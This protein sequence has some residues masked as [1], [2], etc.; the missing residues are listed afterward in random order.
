MTLN[1]SQIRDRFP[2]LNRPVIF[3]DNPGG[4]QICRQ[5][6][7]RINSYLVETN[8]N[9]GGRFAT[10]RAS[11]TLVEEARAALADFLNAARPEE[12]VFGPNMTTLTFAI[13]RALAPRFNPGDT[14]VLTR[15]DHDA[16]FSPWARMAEDRGLRVRVVDFDPE[17]GLL[18]MADMQKALGES[19]R[20]VAFG[21]AS[22]A[23]GTI[24][25]AREITEMAHQAGALVYVDAV[26]YAP[27]G[28][29]DVRQ[30][31]CDFLVCSGYKFFGPHESVLYGRYDL[32][33]EIRAYKVRP[34]GDL[35]PDKFE[36]G[37][38]NFEG[39]AG[40]L[41]ALEYLAWV[42][43]AFG[44]EMAD[45]FAEEYS[46]RRRVYKLAMSAIRSYEYELSRALL[47]TLGSIPGLRLYG[48]ADPQHLDWRVPTFSFT[49]EGFTAGDLA[50][51]LG[52]EGIYTWD[53]N[54]YAVNVTERLGLE[55]TG[56]LLRVGAV[57]YN[58]L[59][60]IQRL[61]EALEKIQ[62]A[63]SAA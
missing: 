30:L 20:L 25:P 19:P 28:P 35:P 14:I 33:E 44:G 47:R 1:P 62:R 16:N 10:S 61:G 38:P 37:T 59:E 57:H 5:S 2:A 32:L 50:S 46:D 8:A 55:Q 56:G 18:D 9:H 52:D 4:T 53:G 13:S 24:N 58:T 36:T 40:L 54:F 63:A 26:Q 45:L 21:Y 27:H 60:E 7:Q 11:D 15:L 41:G 22:N 3:L 6:L 42:G 23:L 43:D 49:L 31:G 34:A 51:R 48:P 17:T 39:I 29:I 12:I